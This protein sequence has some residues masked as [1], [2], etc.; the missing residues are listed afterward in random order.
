MSCNHEEILSH[1]RK[2]INEIDDYFEYSMESK[3]DQKKVRKILAK[4]TD[5]MRKMQ[6]VSHEKVY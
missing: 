3:K 1:Y 6:K 2:A 4:L 5:N